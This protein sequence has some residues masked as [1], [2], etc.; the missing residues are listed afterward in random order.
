MSILISPQ[1]IIFWCFFLLGPLCWFRFKWLLELLFN[2]FW[3]RFLILKLRLFTNLILKNYHVRIGDYRSRWFLRLFWLVRRGSE[4]YFRWW[5]FWSIGRSLIR[6]W[7]KNWSTSVFASYWIAFLKAFWHL[8]KKSLHMWAN[9][10]W[11]IDRLR[12]TW[13]GFFFDWQWWF[14]KPVLNDFLIIALVNY[15]LHYLFL[16]PAKSVVFWTVFV[17]LLTAITFLLHTDI[18]H[19]DFW[20]VHLAPFI[21]VQGIWLGL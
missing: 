1:R 4:R 3:I 12:E 5:A 13:T 2:N 10:I 15:C 18:K 11:K 6:S 9:Y 19:I 8:L 7:E 20:R 17:L 16:L 21:D 14:T